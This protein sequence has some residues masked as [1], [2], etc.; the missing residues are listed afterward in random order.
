[1]AV[2]GGLPLFDDGKCAGGLGI[3]GGTAQQDEDAA[4]VVLKV[5]GFPISDR[6]PARDLADPA[7]ANGSQ[8]RSSASFH[9][10]PRSLATSRAQPQAPLAVPRITCRTFLSLRRTSK[11]DS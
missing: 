4:H 7:A 10:V 6:R 9:D 11:K 3:S 2:G 1:M 8:P 5:Q